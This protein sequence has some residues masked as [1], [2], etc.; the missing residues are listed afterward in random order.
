MTASRQPDRRW[1]TAPQYESDEEEEQEDEVSVTAVRHRLEVQDLKQENRQ[2]RKAQLVLKEEIL[3][4]QNLHKGM[5]DLIIQQQAAS[6]T[7]QPP[8][9]TNQTPV[10]LPRT[11]HRPPQI[12]TPSPAPRTPQPTPR[13]VEVQPRGS[14]FKP[15]AD[16]YTY[17]SSPQPAT[18]H[19]LPYSSPT[20]RPHSTICPETSYRG[21]QPTIP[22]FT[23]RDPSEFARLKLAL[24]NLLPND[25]TELFKYQV[26]LDHLKFE[27]ARLIADSFLNSPWPYTDTM[28][29]L[30]DRF[31]RPH[32]LALTKI[33]AVMDAPDVQPGDL[34][35]FDRFALQIQAL[36]G[37]LRT[38]GPEGNVELQ[39]GSHVV[40]LLTKL[41]P[42]LRASFRRHMPYQSGV[43]YNLLDLAEWLKFE[44]W[45]QDCDDLNSRKEQR[46]KTAQQRSGSVV[47]SRF[48]TVLHGADQTPNTATQV[49]SS[50]KPTKTAQR[51]EQSKVLCPYCDST[52]HFLSQCPTFQKFS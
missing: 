17:K 37:L 8:Q 4:L 45:C 38:L 15:G 32:Q 43:V 21:P 12:A 2:L 46:R 51:P 10:P 20:G 9:H 13:R 52:E 11:I 26:L 29:A 42:D 19:N 28:T 30:T 49:L 7:P 24:D 16:I 3:Q 25:A 39:C 14:P 44:S 31:G 40:R 23:R 41:P 47:K 35:S 22:C 50:F 6:I 48:A 34:A 33:A 27:E 36:V 18:V 1:P 5:Q